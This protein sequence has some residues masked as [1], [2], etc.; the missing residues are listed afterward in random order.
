MRFNLIKRIIA[1]LLMLILS[2][3]PSVSVLASEI[4]AEPETET[5][6]GNTTPTVSG[7]TTPTVSGNTTPTVSG[8]TTPTPTGTNRGY[9]RAK[10]T[11]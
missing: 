1:F 2:I 10:L 7:N 9:I 6:S 4:A 11:L 8:N 3:I 5:V